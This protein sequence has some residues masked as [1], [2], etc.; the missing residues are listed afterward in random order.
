MKQLRKAYYLNITIAV[1]TV[2]SIIWLESGFSLSGQREA[3]TDSGFRIF[4]FYTVDSNLLA[5]IASACMAVAQHNVM[6][7]KQKEVPAWC[8]WLKLAGTAGVALTFIVT[9]VFLAP[10]LPDW[11]FLYT[12]SSFFLHLVIPVLSVVT[13]V[14]LEKTDKIRFKDTFYAL[15]LTMLYGVYY[16][17]NVLTHQ[18]NGEIQKEYDW[19]G[20]FVMGK[21]SIGVAALILFSSVYLVSLI[22]WR[23]NRRKM[24]V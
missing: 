16:I 2:I 6:T 3:L 22:L 4:K 15:L 14:C 12:N 8:F 10:T 7:K 9:L 20:F 23:L 13:F 5:G 19:Y 24:T 17:G 1:L 18:V 11:R 21:E